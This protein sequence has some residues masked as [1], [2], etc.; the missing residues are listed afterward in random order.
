MLGKFWHIISKWAVDKL[1][2]KPKVMILK[3]EIKSIPLKNDQ[4]YPTAQTKS[5]I[6]LHH[7]A[8]GSAA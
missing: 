8:G 4:Y 3:P 7:S 5:H 2:T 1:P 6:V